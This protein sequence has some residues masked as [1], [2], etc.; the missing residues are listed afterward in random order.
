LRI[1]EN[2]IMKRE[3][4]RMESVSHSRENAQIESA[5][6]N[7]FRDERTADSEWRERERV[8]ERRDNGETI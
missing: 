8:R 2:E 1:P 5:R 3:Q 7:K 4:H 6:E